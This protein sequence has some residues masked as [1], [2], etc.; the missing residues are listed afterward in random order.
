[1]ESVDSEDFARYLKRAPE[2]QVASLHLRR[3]EST[4]TESPDGTPQPELSILQEKFSAFEIQAR[5]SPRAENANVFSPPAEI[6]YSHQLDSDSRY[7]RV[8][9]RDIKQPSREFGAERIPR[10]TPGFKESKHDPQAAI[11]PPSA[12]AEPT[13]PTSANPFDDELSDD[14]DLISNKIAYHKAET[15]KFIRQE[16]GDPGVLKVHLIALVEQY[17]VTD[18]KFNLHLATL[19]SLDGDNEKVSQVLKNFKFDTALTPAENAA[20]YLI[21]AVARCRLLDAPAAYKDCRRV[22]Q[23]SRNYSGN[24]DMKALENVA[25]YYASWCS[26]QAKNTADELYYNSLYSSTIGPPILRFGDMRYQLELVSSGSQSSSRNN[27]STT[28]QTNS[29]VSK[30]TSTNPPATIPLKSLAPSSHLLTS[31]NSTLLKLPSSPLSPYIFLDRRP[32]FATPLSERDEKYLWAMFSI[33]VSRPHSTL[34]GIFRIKRSEDPYS[35]PK[36]NTNPKPLETQTCIKFRSQSQIL[37]VLYN[38]IKSDEMSL[39]YVIISGYHLDDSNFKFPMGFAYTIQYPESAPYHPWQYVQKYFQFLALLN[40]PETDL[41]NESIATKLLHRVRLLNL[42]L[43]DHVDLPL[44]TKLQLAFDSIALA[45]SQNVVPALAMMLNL[46]INNKGM[47][48]SKKIGI[49]GRCRNFG[50]SFQALTETP[51]ALLTILESQTPFEL[52]NCLRTLR[53]GGLL[54]NKLK[55]GDFFDCNGGPSLFHLV[56]AYATTSI[57][58]FLFLLDFHCC[59]KPSKKLSCLTRAA[60]VDGYGNVTPSQVLKRR[61]KETTDPKLLDVLEAMIE[62]LTTFEPRTD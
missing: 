56:A 55:E 34:R 42:G 51:I 31:A 1:M 50:D 61:A 53:H 33:E 40:P 10:Y 44:P 7:T 6:D 11:I 21:R 5:E 14:E 30:A 35:R 22:T 18:S 49:R 15:E 20:A 28:P 4:S 8:F 32:Q 46:P 60:A 37:D 36:N 54:D 52:P 9:G 16:R 48:I 12:K 23:I 41:K 57:T 38:C 47:D 13:P 27:K 59:K 3:H 39:A 19:Y 58:P 25:N 2:Q 62:L 24:P 17:K 29:D 26:Q 43:W 45:L